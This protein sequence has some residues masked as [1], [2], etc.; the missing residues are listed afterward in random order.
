MSSPVEIISNR[1]YSI[2]LFPNSWLS[3]A[4]I[5]ETLIYLFPAMNHITIKAKAVS[6]NPSDILGA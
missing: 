2:L 1:G 4:N 6:G 5:R 3:K